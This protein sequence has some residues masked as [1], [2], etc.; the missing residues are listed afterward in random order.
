MGHAEQPDLRAEVP[1]ITRDFKQ[2]CGTGAE[3]QVVEQPLVLQDE[4]R[5]LDAGEAI[6]CGADERCVEAGR[7]GC[8]SC[9]NGS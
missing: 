8:T 6:Q 5:D 7:G 3:D 1:G 4:R 2:H 9:R